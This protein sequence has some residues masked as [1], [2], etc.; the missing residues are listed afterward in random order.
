[1]LSPSNWIRYHPE[2]GCYHPATGYII[3]QQLDT[4]SPSNWICSHTATGY[5]ITQK[6]DVITQQL[7][8]LSPSNY[9]DSGSSERS[10]NI[11][12]IARRHI[13]QHSYV[14]SDSLEPQTAKIHVL[15]I[16]ILESR[17][18]DHFLTE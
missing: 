14:Q 15:F 1:M 6:L 18:Y 16:S 9:P 11:H 12:Q 10:V 5:V 13:P 17:W 7:D 3:T 2:T 4:L 8:T